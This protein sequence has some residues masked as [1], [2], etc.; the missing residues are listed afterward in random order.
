MATPHS[1]DIHPRAY[2]SFVGLVN[3]LL[4]FSLLIL[5]SYIEVRLLKGK[6]RGLVTGL[7][8]F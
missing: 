5:L 8:V 1:L 6:F 3:V 4:G 7:G 2:R